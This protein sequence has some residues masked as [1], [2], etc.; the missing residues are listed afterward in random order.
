MIPFLESAITLH[1][2][3]K[4]SIFSYYFSF[5]LSLD[6]LFEISQYEFKD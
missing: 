1:N 6:R 5:G 3:L 4:K 2:E